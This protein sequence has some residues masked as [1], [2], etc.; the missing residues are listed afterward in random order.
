MIIRKANLE[1]IDKGL[2][3]VY[4]DGFNFHYNGRPDI[5]TD[6][7]EDTLKND[8]ISSIKNSNL[9]IMEDNERIFGYVAYQIKEKHDKV[10]WM[11]E[12]VIDTSYRN[13]GNGKKLID[14]VK[15]IAKQEECKRLEFCCWSFNKNALDMYKHIGFEEQR[16]IFEMDM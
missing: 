9:L 10:L 12:L 11:D 1:D 13:S 6:K 2:L 16:V 15:E 4:I 8:L 5:F 3:D 7:K 14:K